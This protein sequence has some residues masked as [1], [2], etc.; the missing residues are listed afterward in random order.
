MAAEKPANATPPMNA[1]FGPEF[2]ANMPPARN[3]AVTE[4]VRSFLARYYA[5]PSVIRN[6]EEMH[7]HAPTRSRTAS[8]TA[9]GESLLDGERTMHGESM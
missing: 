6:A 3:P 2:R 5:S 8:L 7:N 1:A 9:R 4:L